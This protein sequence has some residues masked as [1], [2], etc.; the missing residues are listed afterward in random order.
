L[1]GS[2]SS[3]Y[4]M[5]VRLLAAGSTA[6][7]AAISLTYMLAV[8]SEHNSIQPLLSFETAKEV[9]EFEFDP[10]K[11]TQLS[12]WK[13]GQSRPPNIA[14]FP[15]FI[16]RN[17]SENIAYDVSV[18]WKSEIS[19]VPEL[20]KNSKRL[21]DRTIQITDSQIDI[22]APLGAAVPNWTY[23]LQLP[24]EQ[25]IS[26]LAKEA[27]IYMP[28]SLYP[29]MALYFVDKLPSETGAKAGPYIFTVS[30]EWAK[31]SAGKP[32]SYR[33]KAFLTNTASNQ[34]SKISGVFNF[35]I[36]RL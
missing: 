30:I 33:V 11:G 5:F 16:L 7:L 29:L 32:Q 19:G 27:E 35:E 20:V 25:R 3:T 18:R 12:A 31:P 23:P 13:H 4:P 14:Y 15:T 28:V 21:A 8:I 1:W 2:Y 10:K 36:E 26:L 24:L 6:A 17:D 9:Y 34:D 22:V